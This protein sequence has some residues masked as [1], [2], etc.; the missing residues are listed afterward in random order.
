VIEVEYLGESLIDSRWNIHLSEF[1][2][3]K[4]RETNE[5]NKGDVAVFFRDGNE[6]IIKFENFEDLKNRREAHAK[7]K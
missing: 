3:K 6:I 1:L 5:L 7:R 2:R 4:I